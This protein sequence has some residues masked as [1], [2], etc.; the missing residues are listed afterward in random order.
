VLI[1]SFL[2]SFI[3][4]TRFSYEKM[5]VRVRSLCLL[6]SLVA[7]IEVSR[8]TPLESS[9]PVEEITGASLKIRDM[10]RPQFGDVPYGVDITSCTVPGKMALTFDDGP[11]EFT[12]KVLDILDAAGAKGTFFLVGTNGGQGITNTADVGVMKRMLSSGH[13]MGSHSWSHA[14]FDEISQA[15]QVNEVVKNEEAFVNAIGVIP[16]YWRPPYTACGSQCMATL[17][18]MVYHVV[19]EKA[20]LFLQ[21]RG[22]GLLLTV[23]ADRLQPRF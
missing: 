21:L 6:T 8:A 2:R 3:P 17:K 10:P 12:A 18:Q 16:T 9:T 13:Q 19:C 20:S 7:S 5:F 23:T 14:N 11:C 22:L 4:V 1:L 15:E